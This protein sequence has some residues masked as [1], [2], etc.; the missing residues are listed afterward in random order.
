MIRVTIVT[1]VTFVI[2]ASQGSVS[3]LTASFEP[4]KRCTVGV[5]GAGECAAAAV[6]VD[7]VAAAAE[8]LWFGQSEI[9]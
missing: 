9:K 8:L 3:A 7:G 2:V 6:A 4:V 5:A 1:L